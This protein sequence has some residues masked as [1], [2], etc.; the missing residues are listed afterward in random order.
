MF[1]D[2]ARSEI[3]RLAELPWTLRRH[4]KQVLPR[5]QLLRNC[6]KALADHRW[7]SLKSLMTIR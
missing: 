4:R 3:V 2:Q 1:L 6:G 5:L 7:L